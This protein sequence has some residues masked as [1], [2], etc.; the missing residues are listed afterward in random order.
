MTVAVGVNNIIKTAALGSQSS[1]TNMPIENLKLDTGATSQAWQT[2]AGLLDVNFAIEPA[3]RQVWRAFGLFRTNLTRGA[4]V[5]VQL[6]NHNPLTQVWYASVTGPMPGYGQIVVVAPQDFQAD[7]CVFYI[8][9]LGNPDGFINV[10]LAFAGPAWIPLKNHTWNSTMGR[11]SVVDE[12][13]SRGGQEYP[14]YR[15]Q[16]R[17]WEVEFDSIEGAELWQS[18]EELDRIAR[19]GGNVL[20]VPRTESPTIA[21]EAV[22]GRVTV[23]ADVGYRAGVADVH[24]WKYRVRERL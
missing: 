14:M 13:I 16:Q 18:A 23:T 9:D 10:P 12:L 5:G 24:N 20:Y 8:T 11:D 7:A 22:F 19:Y 4:T 15:Y 6:V 1:A 21:Q 17:R 2:R 3:T